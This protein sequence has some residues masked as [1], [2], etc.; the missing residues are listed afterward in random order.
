MRCFRLGGAKSPPQESSRHDTSSYLVNTLGAVLVYSL[1]GHSK[2][3]TDIAISSDNSLLASASEDGDVRIWGVKKGHPVAI[4]RAHE[5]GVTMV[6]WSTLSPFHLTTCGNDGSA[7]TW[8]IQGVWSHSE[9]SPIPKKI[10][11]RSLYG[12]EFTFNSNYNS[13]PLIADMPHGSLES[14]HKYEKESIRVTCIAHC[15][16]GGQFATSTSTGHVFLWSQNDDPFVAKS[17]NDLSE[18]FE[19]ELNLKIPADPIQTSLP[20]AVLAGHK[21]TITDLKVS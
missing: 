15:P 19:D 8:D 12:E 17:D 6:S 21:D 9:K 10:S 5:G 16:V 20:L 7:K 3:I 13:L 1:R 18:L 2:E 11:D 14:T 4:L